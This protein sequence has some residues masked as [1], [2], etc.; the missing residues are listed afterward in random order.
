[1]SAQVVIA[2]LFGV[3]LG[4]GL[5]A[6]WLRRVP[7]TIHYLAAVP[8][9]GV[10]RHYK[11]GAY[12]LLTIAKLSEDH[13]TEVAVYVSLTNGETW[14]RPLRSASGVDAWEDMVDW[15]LV[16]VRRPRFLLEAPYPRDNS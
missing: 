5:M 12:K 11:G 9:I 15:P 7:R 4:V 3:V 10:Y 13:E 6:T 16:K 1:M 14:V 8:V 2:L